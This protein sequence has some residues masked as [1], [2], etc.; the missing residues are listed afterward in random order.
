[1]VVHGIISNP[2]L[3]CQGCLYIIITL[4]DDDLIVIKMRLQS[5]S[6]NDVASEHEFQKETMNE[7]NETLNNHDCDFPYTCYFQHWRLTF[8]K[9]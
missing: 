1:M 5:D 6:S 8:V 2:A 4:L 9:H 3:E 7:L